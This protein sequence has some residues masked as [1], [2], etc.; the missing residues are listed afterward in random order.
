MCKEITYP[1][2]NE[3]KQIKVTQKRREGIAFVDPF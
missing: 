3:I 1:A 2:E